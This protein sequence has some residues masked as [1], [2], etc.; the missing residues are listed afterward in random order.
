MIYP[1]KQR[2]GTTISNPAIR[3]Q[4]QNTSPWLRPTKSAGQDSPALIKNSL[5]SALK[6]P[7]TNPNKDRTR[8]KPINVSF[9]LEIVETRYFHASDVPSACKNSAVARQI[10]IDQAQWELTKDLQGN[11]RQPVPST[12][13]V[14]LDCF[15]SQ[16]K[17]R[18]IGKIAVRNIDYHK[19][20]TARFTFDN[21]KTVSETQALHTSNTENDL[22]PA[23]YDKFEFDIELPIAGVEEEMTI[24]L[25][26]SYIVAGQKYWDNNGQENYQF[27]LRGIP[28]EVTDDVET[29]TRAEPSMSNPTNDLMETIPLICSSVASTGKR[30]YDNYQPLPIPLHARSWA[31][32][33][34]YNLDSSLSR[35]ST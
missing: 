25:C 30:E 21:W 18:L 23:N 7:C 31:L 13:I 28:L 26:M 17:T 34:R 33:Y 16:D 35:I 14:L 9:Q 6:Q 19:L 29:T 5:K 11:E 10:D 20:V 2:T 8:S 3:R 4:C 1:S 32:S 27:E 22:L 15:T 24:Q 12:E